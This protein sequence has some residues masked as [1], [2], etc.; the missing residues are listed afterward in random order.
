MSPATAVHCR[1][2]DQARILCVG[3]DVEQLL[4]IQYQLDSDIDFVIVGCPDEG[5]A[6]LAI[7]EP[8][9]VIISDQQTR[10]GRGQVFLTRLRRHSPDAERVM[11]A[12]RTDRA[13]MEEAA[14]DARVMRLLV[15]PCPPLVLRDAVSDALL[16][17]RARRL[18]ASAVPYVTPM[19]G[20]P[21][22]AYRTA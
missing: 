16:R 19:G 3:D 8:F 13:A 18:R 20:H 12:R 15:R 6:A 21:C 4:D 9:D 11:L 22:S 2:S 7:E 5:Y 14:R 1:A 17:H 10:S